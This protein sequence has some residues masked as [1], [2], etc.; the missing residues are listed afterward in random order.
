MPVQLRN[1]ELVELLTADFLRRASWHDWTPVL[2][3]GG[4]LSATGWARYEV[5]ETTVRLAG[6]LTVGGAGLVGQPITLGGI[7]SPFEIARPGLD[8]VHGSGLIV[9]GG[10]FYPMVMVSPTGLDLQ[11]VGGPAGLTLAA[12]DN[13]SFSVTYER[14]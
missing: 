12:G 3:Q 5:Q 13:L 6:K 7:P 4:S 2:S 10:T 11:F 1:A 9:A 14:A 8:T